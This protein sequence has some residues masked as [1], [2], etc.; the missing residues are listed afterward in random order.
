MLPN[1]CI[2][3]L[4][5]S[6][7]M[8]DVYRS[9]TLEQRRITCPDPHMSRAKTMDGRPKA[10]VLEAM[11]R[12]GL[13]DDESPPESPPAAGPRTPS[14]R[15]FGLGA[16]APSPRAFGL[17]PNPISFGFGGNGC[18]VC[19][20]RHYWGEDAWQGWRA[21]EPLAKCHGGY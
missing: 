21:R 3:C 12:C 4:V 11:Q 2:A 8:A 15:A 20:E 19:A 5:W 13:L 9:F 14:P 7:F 17:G 6:Q 1:P 16:R 18:G 10:M